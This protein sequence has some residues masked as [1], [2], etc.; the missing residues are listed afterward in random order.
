M[1]R[2]A[3]IRN[4]YPQGGGYTGMVFD[5]AYAKAMLQASMILEKTKE[6]KA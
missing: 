1:D 6:M 5:I 3:G 2:E 4:Q